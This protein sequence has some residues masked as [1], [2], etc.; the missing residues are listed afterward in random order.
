[1]SPS[2][3]TFS[4]GER[5]T[6]RVAVS[7]DAPLNAVAGT[8]TFSSDTLAVESVS[9]GSVLNFWVTEPAFSNSAGTIHFEGVSLSGFAGGSG[10]VIT[11]TLRAKSPGSASI[12]FQT[13]QVLANDGQGT[14]ITSGFSG[15]TYTIVAASPE[16]S[17]RAPEGKKEEP[18]PESDG[19]VVELPTIRSYTQELAQGDLQK[20]VG[21]TYPHATV[22][23]RVYNEV[24]TQIAEESDK[25][26]FSGDFEVLVSKSFSPGTYTMTAF[27]DHEGQRS[28]E[29]SKFLFVVNTSLEHDLGALITKYLSLFALI[30]F[31]I[32]GVCASALYAWHHFIQLRHTVQ[33]E[34]KEAE[35]ILGKSFRLFERDIAARINELK[36]SRKTRAYTDDE[37]AFLQQLTEDLDQARAI[38]EKEVRDVNPDKKS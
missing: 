34:L 4:V 25:S 8:L 37:I 33:K 31:F 2:S 22:F 13:G 5:V 18:A 35:E 24:G 21:F 23:I 11:A 30:L 14:D 38:I 28:A 32:I 20:V 16:P 15:G 6:V 27:V 9:K 29:T 3:G 17:S 10:S 26:D 36:K 7:S 12:K 1:M 19:A